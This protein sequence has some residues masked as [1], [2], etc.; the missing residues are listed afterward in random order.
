MSAE[1]PFNSPPKKKPEVAP[2]QDLESSPE[3]SREIQVLKSRMAHA[4]KTLRGER[5]FGDTVWEDLQKNLTSA[6]EA[7]VDVSAFNDEAREMIAQLPSAEISN[8]LARADGFFATQD[9]ASA[10]SWHADAQTRLRDWKKKGGIPPDKFLEF[11]NRM[12]LLG[13]SLYGEVHPA[14]T[15]QEEGGVSRENN[16]V[17]FLAVR[18]NQPRS[19][20]QEE[21]DSLEEGK[22]KLS[23]DIKRIFGE[24]K[25]RYETQTTEAI[26]LQEKV[27]SLL[28]TKK[29][30]KMRQGSKELPWAPYE[31]HMLNM[32]ESASSEQDLRLIEMAFA[33]SSGNINEDMDAQEKALASLRRTLSLKK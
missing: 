2:D 26:Q 19:F 27:D 33:E 6:E 22:E 11:Q 25:E 32:V 3:D 16:V 12:N 7:G 31:A 5:M 23:T 1:N 9:I 14:E 20:S 18:A 10:K 17:D 30:E 15:G 21:L 24:L 4:R 13:S 28:G 8:V 29:A